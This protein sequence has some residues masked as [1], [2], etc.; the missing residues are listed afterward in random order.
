MF[1]EIIFKGLLIFYIF[2]HAA[3]T[4]LK[5]KF[6]QS[7]C[8]WPMI[9]HHFS[10]NYSH[11]IKVLITMPIDRRVD[12]KTNVED[13]NKVDKLISEELIYRNVI[14]RKKSSAQIKC[15]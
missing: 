2:S 7:R 8:L 9:Y 10:A 6:S 5:C 13:K 3:R 12:T 14:W 15:K 1:S 4:M 11:S